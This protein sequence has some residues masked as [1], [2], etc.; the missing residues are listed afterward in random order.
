[1]AEGFEPIESQEALDAIVR[2]R[3]ARERRKYADYDE[4]KE[5]A[6]RLDEIEAANKTDLEKAQQRIAELEKAERDRAE[7]DRVRGVRDKVAKA[8]G[9]P[10]ELIAGDDEESMTEFAKQVAAFAKQPAAPKVGES[11]K[12]AA[13]A[14]PGG[15]DDAMREFAANLF[16]G[17]E[18]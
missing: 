17:S 5:K 2:E 6:A 4:L 15:K 18:D 8:T 9:V 3:L 16:G 14:K 1:M 12:F 13:K 7:A 11:G 10:A